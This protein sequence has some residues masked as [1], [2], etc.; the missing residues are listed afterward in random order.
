M[1]ITDYV[2]KQKLAEALSDSNVRHI[3]SATLLEA[4]SAVELSTL[5]GLPT[6][7]L[8]RYMDEL[9][10]LGL[11][12]RERL[13]VMESGGRFTLYRSMVKSITVKYE[14]GDL[15]VD[16]IPNEKILGRFLRF[17]SYMQGRV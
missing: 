4:K 13:V 6:R 3:L 7:T 5:L 16:V 1:L 2:A 9:C 11:L 8:Y 12:V 10:A 15:G 17:W 14:L